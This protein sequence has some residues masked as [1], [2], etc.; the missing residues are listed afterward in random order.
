MTAWSGKRVRRH[1]AQALWCICAA[2][3]RGPH[4][5]QYLCRT[6]EGCCSCH[7]FSQFHRARCLGLL[8]RD[9]SHRV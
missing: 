7:D 1:K 2:R 5:V 4:A 6:G 9:C 8:L 3:H